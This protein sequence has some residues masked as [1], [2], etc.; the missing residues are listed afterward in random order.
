M[1]YGDEE[2]VWDDLHGED[3]DNGYWLTSDDIGPFDD[4][5]PELPQRSVEEIV[6]QFHVDF[7]GCRLGATAPYGYPGLPHKTPAGGTLV[8][9]AH[10]AAVWL[11]DPS[12]LSEDWHDPADIGCMS[13]RIT[14]NAVLPEAV[15]V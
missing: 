7:G 10:A 15:N 9:I 2:A 1:I 12:H 3:L 8:G 5:G 14:T 13:E 6:A 11:V 4:Y